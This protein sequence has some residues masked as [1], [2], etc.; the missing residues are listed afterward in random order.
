MADTGRPS[1]FTQDLADRICAFLSEGKS[2]RAVCRMD[3]M[4]AMQTI[5]RWLRE[6]PS[7]NEQYVRASE[8]RADAMFEEMIEIADEGINDTYTTEDGRELVSH[9]VINRSRLRVDTRKWAVARMAPR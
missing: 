9:D 8:E 6:K 4:P 2:L 1:I 7:F 3:D 5:W